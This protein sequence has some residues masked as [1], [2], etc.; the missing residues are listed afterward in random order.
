MYCQTHM[1]P[2]RESSKHINRVLTYPRSLLGVSSLE[3]SS[4]Q[5]HRH[6]SNPRVSLTTIADA[7]LRHHH[8]AI[9]SPSYQPQ[10]SCS[11]PTAIS[12][13][14][15]NRLISIHSTSLGKSTPANNRTHSSFTRFSHPSFS[16][17]RDSAVLIS[18]GPERSYTPIVKSCSIP[19]VT[20]AMN[21]RNT[22]RY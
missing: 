14:P 6:P 1:T 13:P 7:S 19:G 9:T 16:R 18:R 15:N 12:P 2:C 22:T 21:L 10:S 5:V 17:Q 11:I 20:D 8:H 4:L 3:C